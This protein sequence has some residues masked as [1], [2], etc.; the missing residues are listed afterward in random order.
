MES[1]DWRAKR[2]YTGRGGQKFRNASPYGRPN[3]PASQPDPEAEKAIEQGRRLYVGNLPYK[4]KVTDIQSL[5]IEISDLIQD[6][7]MSI[8]PMTG[9]NPSYCFVDFFTEDAALKTIDNYNGQIF[10]KRPLKVRPGVKPRASS[11]RNTNAHRQ[12]SNFE[13]ANDAPIESPYAFNRWRRLDA[14]VDIESMNKTAIEAGRRLYVGNLPR[15]STQA[16]HNIRIRD[17]FKDYEVEVISKMILPHHGFRNPTKARYCFVDLKSRE[18]T[19]AAIAALNGIQKWDSILEIS[20]SSGI[21]GKLHERSRVYVGGLPFFEDI[22]TLKCEMKTLFG[23]FG[24]IKVVSTILEEHILGS[25]KNTGYCFVEFANGS[26]SDAAITAVDQ[27]SRWGGTVTVRQ[28]K[29][30][31]KAGHLEVGDELEEGEVSE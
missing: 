22:N 23:S 29:P 26:Q 17:L 27:T 6:I 4:A 19:D 21:S 12:D 15:V 2:E 9:R 28:A 18:D 8:D 14:R 25:S 5:F 20:R 24:E 3:I 7:T 30:L 1:H 16:E 13:P 31:Q 10:M 11:H